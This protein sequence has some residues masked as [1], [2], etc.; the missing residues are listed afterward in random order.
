MLE[1]NIDHF[2]MQ[3]V[4]INFEWRKRVF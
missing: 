4:S 1:A 3:A 2:R